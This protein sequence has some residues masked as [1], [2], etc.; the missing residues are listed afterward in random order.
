MF[1]ACRSA[2]HDVFAVYGGD[3]TYAAS[4]SS[5][6]DQIVNYATTMTLS[7]DQAGP[8]TTSSSLTFTATVTGD[9]SVGTVTYFAGPGLTNP[10]GSPIAVVN[11]T[12]DS[13]PGYTFPS[14]S[15]TVT[16][17]YSGGTGFAGSTGTLTIQ[18]SGSASAPSITS[19][20]INQNISALYNAAGQGSTPGAQ[21]SM[22]EDIVYTFS[23]PVNIL[24]NSVDPNV[25]TI[26]VASGW[27]GTVPG[28]VEWA[29]VAGSNSTQ[30]EV[31]F[32]VNPNASGSQ[33]GALASIANGCYTITISDA[34][35]IT[36]VSDGQALSVTPGAAPAA[37][38][39]GYA[40][41]SFY[42]LFG[43]ITG[44]QLVNAYD[45][46]QFE[47][48][49]TTYNPAFDYYED[50]LVNA[51]DNFQFN[52]NLTVNFSGFTPTL[53]IGDAPVEPLLYQSD[54]Q[55]VGAFRVPDYSNST[56]SMSF[57]AGALAYNPADNSLF[58]TGQG[59]SIAEI[60]IPSTIVDS[61]D[62]D[63]LSTATVLQPWKNVLSNLPNQLSGTSDGAPIGGLMVYNGELIGTQFA[64]YGG[65]YS[66]VLSH[67]VLNS[68][69]L[70]TA[71]VE[72]LYQVGSGGRIMAGY[73]T[74]I[75]SEW[76]APLGGF[77]ALTGLSDWPIIST[78]SAGP[79]AI[80]FNP[81][82]L[83][84]AND[85]ASTYLAYTGGHQLGAYTGP[86]N[87]M[88]SGTTSIDGD[89]FVPG[90]SSILYF[91][92]TGTNY[93]GYG[94]PGPWDGTNDATGPQSLNG[95]YAF[96]VWAYNAND[97]VAVQQGQ[98]QPY[99]VMPYDVWNF[100]LPIPASCQPEGLAFDPGTGRIY[101]AI[102]NADNE[103]PY[104]HLPL[105]EVFQ[106]NVPTGTPVAA[107][108]QIGTL[109]ATPS[110]PP[111]P[112]YPSPGSSPPQ[113]F[114]TYAGPINE[115]DNAVLTAGNVYAITSGA[116]ITQVA[117]Y[118]S[119]DNSDPFSSNDTLLGYGTGTQ[120]LPN[121]GSTN[122]A[123]TIS[124]E[125]LSS[126]TYTIFAQAE[127][128]NGLLSDPISMTLTIS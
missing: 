9:P 110:I 88:Q 126:G 128:S 47:S 89:A 79:A 63:N 30:W 104:S 109:A 121:G 76:Q 46:L 54:V 108:P 107:P 16:A 10:I 49:L 60:S 22:V 31:D 51:A 85:P 80:G 69:D 117:F 15:S 29:P 34:Q 115:G 97:L 111:D 38:N 68:L 91:G 74:P 26:A 94:E 21:R 1:P 90:T 13:T 7:A 3:A 45:N 32:G 18:V 57:G 27:I 14:G 114:G 92:A 28:T 37:G 123:L 112:N 81:G 83:G 87:P 59:Q 64:Y 42:R 24:S 98:L 62:L 43:D 113:W 23:E 58:I 116:N 44:G 33:A 25:F 56:D 40:T 71:S 50:G 72:G 122:W 55:Y 20:V 75:P 52:N 8:Y 41:Q 66:Q 102:P 67:F 17:V 84:S 4:Q 6:V 100:T 77:T 106:V 12:A 39:P 86:A 82:D 119:S 65:A 124:T 61:S 5:Q 127:D 103:V 53:M 118:L 95:Q 73:M 70:S 78:E 99:Q 19:V 96:Q 120:N 35:S 101:M 11:G 2:T 93:E 125:G 36:A 105:I 48:A